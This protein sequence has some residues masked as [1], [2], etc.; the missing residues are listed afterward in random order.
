ME[1]LLNISAQYFPLLVA[2]AVLETVVEVWVVNAIWKWFKRV[3]R[4]F[5][6]KC[7]R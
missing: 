5:S 4:N 1:T 6:G 3:R 7:Y 2:L